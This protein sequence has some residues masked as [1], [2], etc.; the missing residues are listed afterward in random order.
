MVVLDSDS[1]SERLKAEIDPGHY[2]SFP[3]WQDD[4]RNIVVPGRNDKGNYLRSYDIQTKSWRVLIAEMYATIDRVFPKDEFVYF[5][6][7][8]TGVQNI[9]A[10]K[11]QYKNLAVLG[12][13]EGLERNIVQ[14]NSRSYIA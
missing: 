8:L 7:S 3:R 9:F 12:S 2:I 13:P 4:N 10:L 11:D 14:L 6:S 5:S 1:G